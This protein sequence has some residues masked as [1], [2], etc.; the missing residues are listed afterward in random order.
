MSNATVKGNGNAKSEP[1]TTKVPEIQPAKELNIKT[2]LSVEQIN[3]R[4]NQLN[5]LFAKRDKLIS[6]RTKLELF[7]MG[8]DDVSVRFQDNSGNSWSTGH[9]SAIKKLI[10]VLAD[11]LEVSQIETEALIRATFE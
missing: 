9:P 5:T 1:T 2:D 3:T 11:D 7:K 8:A 4:I 6:S 10:K